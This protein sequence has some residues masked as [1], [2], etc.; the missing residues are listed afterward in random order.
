MPR[1]DER[2]WFEMFRDAGREAAGAVPRGKG[3][4]TR[5]R[6]ACLAARHAVERA[7]LAAKLSALLLEDSTAARIGTQH[8]RAI[9]DELRVQSRHNF[10]RLSARRSWSRILS[11]EWR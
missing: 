6:A 8:T 5:S 2:G 9:R 7:T 4:I 10:A 3:A 11:R 1:G